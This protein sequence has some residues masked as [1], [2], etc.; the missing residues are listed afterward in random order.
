MTKVI[1]IIWKNAGKNRIKNKMRLFT[2]VNII[3]L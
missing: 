2:L 1:R 3:L